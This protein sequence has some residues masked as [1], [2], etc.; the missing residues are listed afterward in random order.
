MGYGWVHLHN[1]FGKPC[2]YVLHLGHCHAGQIWFT[3]VPIKGTLKS[4]KNFLDN[5]VLSSFCAFL[6]QEFGEEPHYKKHVFSQITFFAANDNHNLII[7]NYYYYY[8]YCKYIGLSE[9]CTMK[10]LRRERK[11]VFFFLYLHIL[12]HAFS[13]HFWALVEVGILLTPGNIPH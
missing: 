11:N 9:M 1:K 2:L 4:Y 6:W 12:L 8:E 7:I 5:S 3:L 13:L 10:I